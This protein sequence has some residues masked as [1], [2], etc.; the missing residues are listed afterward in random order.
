MHV[1]V[2]GSGMS[3]LT[4]A[5]RITEQGH[6]VCVLDK[7]RNPGGRL[8]TRRFAGGATADHGAQFFTAR[9]DVLKTQIEQWIGTGIVHEW[10]RGFSSDDGHPR[11]AAAGGMAELAKAMTT[12]IDVKQSVRVDTIRQTEA[13]WSVTWVAGHGRPAGSMQ[14]D[15]VILTT[16]V[17]QSAVLL[18][19]DVVIPDLTY[20]PT[21]CLLVALDRPA[22]IPA[23]GGLQF[24]ADLNRDDPTW[25]WI[26]DNVAKG[27]S[28]LPALT[29]HV[30]PDVSA[31][32]LE[33]S[34]ESLHRD[35][36]T[37][38]DPWLGGAGVLESTVHKWR[39]AIP[40][41][42]YPERFWSSGDGQL[43]LAGDA[44]GS[45]R[46]EGAFLSGLA[47]ADFLLSTAA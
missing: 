42:P 15:A 38:A 37:A 10:C 8:A 7:G 23:P 16:P 40:E 44:F 33:E 4:A 28:V 6:T 39:Y 24:S 2:V 45:P 32:R 46:L 3:G 22:A 19:P 30:R 47:A 43:V 1:V 12:G 20:R 14:G 41:S 11:Y 17:P 34:A 5:R 25:S 36:L 21:L 26:G 27:T 13:G 29:F 9:S 18:G 31:A 35:L